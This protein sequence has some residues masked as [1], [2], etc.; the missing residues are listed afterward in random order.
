MGVDALSID[1]G[2]IGA[3]HVDE[4]PRAVVVDDFGVAFGDVVFGEGNVRRGDAS[5]HHLWLIKLE[6]S[7]LP[8]LF[9]YHY[10]QH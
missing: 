3:L 5:N 6:F 4:L 7:L 2:T 8:V 10:A 1:V 9:P